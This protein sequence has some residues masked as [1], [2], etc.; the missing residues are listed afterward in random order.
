MENRVRLKTVPS[1]DNKKPR[2]FS[3]RET[4]KDTRSTMDEVGRGGTRSRRRTS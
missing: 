4:V 2:G 3:V 1:S